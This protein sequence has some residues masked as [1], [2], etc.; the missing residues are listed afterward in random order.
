MHAQMHKFCIYKKVQ[1]HKLLIISDNYTLKVGLK[2]NDMI[3]DT[4]SILLK[5]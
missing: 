5:T 4:F 2:W 1:V 3:L